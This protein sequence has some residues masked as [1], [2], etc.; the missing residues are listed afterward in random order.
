MFLDSGAWQLRVG[1]TLLVRDAAITLEQAGVSATDS[2]VGVAP[3]LNFTADWA[4][5]DRWI[6][7][8]DFELL[9]GGPGRALDLALKVSY[10]LTDQWRL[11]VGYRSLEGGVDTD[12][13]Y[14]FSWFNY[15]FGSIAYRF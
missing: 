6:A 2:N 14:N 3:L 8:A 10:D 5:A 9:A 7:T 12:D 15:L 4:F 11:G 13:T 1:G